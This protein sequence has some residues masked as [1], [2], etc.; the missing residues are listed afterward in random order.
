MITTLQAN[1]SEMLLVEEIVRIMKLKDTNAPRRPQRI[2]LLGSPGSRKEHY[3]VKIAEKYK[4]VYVQ[5]PQLVKEV[6]R[7]NGDNDYA[8]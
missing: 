2:I 3:A 6:T 5:V 8:R 4:M 1:E 7:R